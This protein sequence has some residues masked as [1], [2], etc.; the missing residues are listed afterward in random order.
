M[1]RP[2]LGRNPEF[3]LQ[4]ASYLPG[5][6]FQENDRYFEKLFEFVCTAN[7]IT[8]FHFLFKITPNLKLTQ[9]P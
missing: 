7:F 1:R 8:I 2:H 5:N 9:T 6:A 4:G 3:L